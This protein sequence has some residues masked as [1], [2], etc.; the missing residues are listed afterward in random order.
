M[1]NGFSTKSI[2]Q[3][4]YDNVTFECTIAGKIQIHKKTPSGIYF[5]EY[6]LKSIKFQE[7]GDRITWSYKQSGQQDYKKFKTN[8]P[9]SRDR[10]FKHTMDKEYK[11]IYFKKN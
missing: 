10:F 5:Q 11:Y 2:A 4:N 3:I 1:G 6:D 9:K 8:N 7:T